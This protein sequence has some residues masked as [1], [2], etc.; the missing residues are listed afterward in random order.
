MLINERANCNLQ[1][2]S[3]QTALDLACE[4]G[5]NEV[6]YTTPT[7]SPYKYWFIRLLA[8]C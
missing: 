7:L 8:Y 2:V 4:N 6:S 1:N 5:N 3:G